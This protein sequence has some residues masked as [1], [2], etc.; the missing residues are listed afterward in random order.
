LIPLWDVALRSLKHRAARS[1][2]TVLGVALAGQLYITLAGTLAAYEEDLD[3]QLQAM[4]GRIVV[5]QP[6]ARP[7]ENE[8]FPSFSSSMP[9]STA[10]AL[11]SSPGLDRPFS[12]AV[13][14]LPLARPTLPDGPPAALLVGIEPGHEAAFL[15]GVTVG[16]GQPSLSSE[17]SV[18]LGEEAA[19][20]YAAQAG[21]ASLAIGQSLRLVGQEFTVTGLLEP[22][23]WLYDGA[24]LMPLSTAQSLFSLPTAVSGVMLSVDPAADIAEVQHAIQ[25]QF[26]DLQIRAAGDLI[27]DVSR[28]INTYRI[29]F[30]GINS[31][32][33]SGV[34]IILA[35]VLLIAVS[36]QRREIATLR[37]LGATRWNVLAHVVVQASLLTLAGMVIAWPI[38]WM[39]S[40]TLLR[41]FLVTFDLA[42]P[43]WVEVLALGL[44]V[45]ALAAAAPAWRAVRVDPIEVLR[46]E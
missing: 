2:L 42:F 6:M 39:V 44:V 1:A 3:R 24:V 11:L 38:W 35:V 14:F 12:S 31:M 34:A 4:G 18:I 32:V 13:L 33:L 16:A 9:A 29:F 27:E 30:R 15:G 8:G 28:I 36:E 10:E 23:S 45:A 43:R 20:Y 22:A 46:D 37:A 5:Q 21:S 17:N 41:D 25:A 19:G 40:L 7:G 26:P